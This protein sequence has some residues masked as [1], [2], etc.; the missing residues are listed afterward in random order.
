MQVVRAFL[1][2]MAAALCI[3]VAYFWVGDAPSK[4][5][6]LIGIMA[7]V[8]VAVIAVIVANSWWPRGIGEPAMRMF[9]FLLLMGTVLV[10]LSRYYRIGR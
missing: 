6:V 3:G 10:F 4:G 2:G 8:T 5:R 7:A 9:A 1:P